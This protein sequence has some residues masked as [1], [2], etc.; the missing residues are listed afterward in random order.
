LQIP[1]LSQ[2]PEQH[3]PHE[4]P[5]LQ[6]AAQPTPLLAQSWTG[7]ASPQIPVSPQ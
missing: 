3:E 4:S 2:N 5:Q 6:S 1:V 7:G